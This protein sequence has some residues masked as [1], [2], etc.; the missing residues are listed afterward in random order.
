MTK[1][2]KAS[3]EIICEFGDEFGTFSKE[4]IGELFVDIHASLSPMDPLFLK[5]LNEQQRNC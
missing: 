2:I 4:D 1:E 5:A 3:T